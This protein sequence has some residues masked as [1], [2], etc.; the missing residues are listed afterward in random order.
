MATLVG[1]PA[2]GN[3]S[4]NDGKVQFTSETSE[5]DYWIARMRFD[6]EAGDADID[7]VI[8]PD[9]AIPH[10]VSETLS[11]DDEMMQSLLEII[12]GRQ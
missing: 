5:I 1:E 8:K 4:T 3:H 7:E 12:E 6:V 9:I 2:G 10:T 11:R